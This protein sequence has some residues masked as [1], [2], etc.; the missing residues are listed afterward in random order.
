VDIV[1]QCPS[2][3]ISE[4][5]FHGTF[6]IPSQTLLGNAAESRYSR[7]HAA[8]SSPCHQGRA[9]QACSPASGPTFLAAVLI[10][11]LPI[12][13]AMLAQA[14]AKGD[15]VAS[16]SQVSHPTP[17]RNVTRFLR[18]RRAPLSPRLIFCLRTSRLQCTVHPKNC[19]A[20]RASRHLP[21]SAFI[22]RPWTRPT[23]LSKGEYRVQ[24]T[25]WLCT[26]GYT[27]L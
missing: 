18:P 14:Q 13:S 9:N 16:Q 23:G 11:R 12:R 25:V 20:H 6:S 4:A 21:H 17:P 8:R 7:L 15:P 10:R 3:C 2:W 26:R 22:E 27:S 19:T 5:A 1:S 24:G